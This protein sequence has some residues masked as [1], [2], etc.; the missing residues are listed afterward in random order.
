MRANIENKS[1]DMEVRDINVFLPAY[2]RSY[3]YVSK[4]ES[5]DKII[6]P[7]FP[8]VPHPYDP[9]KRIP[10][11]YYPM[12]SPVVAEIAE[13]G[14]DVKEATEAELDAKDAQEDRIKELTAKVKELEATTEGRGGVVGTT[15]ETIILGE[16][17]VVGKMADVLKAEPLSVEYDISSD[18]AAD[19]KEVVTPAPEDILRQQQE[20][21]EEPE[22]IVQVEI[23]K[24]GNIV[25]K[26]TTKPGLAPAR[27]PRKPDV[28]IEPGAQ[29]DGMQ[30]RDRDNQKRIARDIAPEPEVDEEKEVPF[31]KETGR[32]SK[33]KPT[34]KGK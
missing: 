16:E 13:D 7:M 10:V 22:D 5:P 20:A 30:S 1:M 15:K 4:N 27:E 2:I 34:V 28:V 3:L 31:D 14:K 8:T 32:D 33:G 6:F 17:G 26:A 21:E 11:E 29:L 24:D 19:T 23:D 18:P 25:P 12:D 9:S